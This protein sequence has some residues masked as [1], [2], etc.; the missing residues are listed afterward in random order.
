MYAYIRIYSCIYYISQLIT[1]LL[2]LLSLNYCIS[3]LLCCT[4]LSTVFKK[5][6]YAVTVSR[7]E[8]SMLK[9]SVGYCVYR[10]L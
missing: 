3:G 8:C 4:L 6:A 2:F 7:P 5:P 9:R 10:G 1:I